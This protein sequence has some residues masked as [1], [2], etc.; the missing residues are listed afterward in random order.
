MFYLG[1]VYIFYCFAMRIINDHFTMS[2]VCVCL[3]S[4]QAL[5]FRLAEAILFTF[6]LRLYI[7]FPLFRINLLSFV[8][9]SQVQYVAHATT[10]INASQRTNSSLCSLL[11]N[12]VTY[13]NN[14]MIP[15]K[16]F[17]NIRKSFT[18]HLMRS[19]NFSHRR[20]LL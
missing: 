3:C 20:K 2:I 15:R 4:Y 19:L 9:S 5:V 17:A 1:N 11:S 12:P 7:L 18:I 8:S 16:D 6:H 13:R 10:S 14:L